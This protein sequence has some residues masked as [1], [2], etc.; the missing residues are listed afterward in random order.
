MYILLG[1][2]VTS[3]NKNTFFHVGEKVGKKKKKRKGKKGG[4]EGKERKREGRG[5][6]GGKREEE[7]QE[8]EAVWMFKF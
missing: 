2:R 6:E 3:Y 8:E 5:K 1:S 7:G 4:K